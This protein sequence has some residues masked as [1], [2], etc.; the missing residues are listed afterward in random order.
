MLLVKKAVRY[1]FDFTLT[2]TLTLK[3][4]ALAESPREQQKKIQLTINSHT[5]HDAIHCMLSPLRRHI[6]SRPMT[7]LPLRYNLRTAMN[8]R[9][10]AAAASPPPLC[11]SLRFMPLNKI[12]WTVSPS[13]ENTRT[14]TSAAIAA[15]SLQNS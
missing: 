13:L 10:G 14:L 5:T 4:T 6:R 8:E 3:E 7:G 2:L 1:V 11:L 12:R 9:D 15:R